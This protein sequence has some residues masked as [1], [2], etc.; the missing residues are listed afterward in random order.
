MTYNKLTLQQSGIFATVTT[1]NQGGG[2]WQSG[3]PPVIDSGGYAYVFVGSGRQSA[4]PR[5]AA[6]LQC[7]ERF[8]RIVELSN[9]PVTRRI[10]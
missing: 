9:E 8:S 4:E 7:R 3:R 6:R 2:V 10:R 1:G 5:R